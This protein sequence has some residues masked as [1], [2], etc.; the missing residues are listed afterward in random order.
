LYLIVVIDGLFLFP[1]PPLILFS[2]DTSLLT[3]SVL[4]VSITASEEASRL[5]SALELFRPPSASLAVHLGPRH[6]HR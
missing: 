5:A 4:I 3:R 2:L 1:P 6:Q